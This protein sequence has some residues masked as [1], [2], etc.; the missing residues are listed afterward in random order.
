MFTV[1]KITNK[2]NKKLYIGI[3][4]KTIEERFTRH[5]NSA[6]KSKYRIHAA[7]R[8][9]GKDNFVIETLAVVDTQEEANALEVQLIRQL[10]STDYSVGYNMANG[11]AGKSLN[12]SEETRSKIKNSVQAHRDSM[13]SSEKKALTSKAN[14]AKRGTSE[15]EETKKMK[16]AAQKMRWANMSEEQRKAMARKPRISK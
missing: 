3:T 4:M 9:Y 13:T 14:E 1:Y 5:V 11:G 7:I 6:E 2:I 8:K 15:S 10:N 16:S 12:I